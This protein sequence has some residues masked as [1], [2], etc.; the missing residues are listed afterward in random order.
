MAH[1]AFI[2]YSN[3]DRTVADAA[4]AVLES[5]GIRCWIAPRDITPGL[6]WSEAIVDAIERSKVMVL[7]LSAHANGS[8]QIKREVE[9]GVNHGLPIIP[10][11]IEDVP[12]S[13]ALEYFIS[14]PHW[15]DALTPPLEEHLQYLADTVQLLLQRRVGASGGTDKIRVQRESRHRWTE[16]K[17]KA[18][19]AAVGV[20]ALAVV[21]TGA[22]AW[23]RFGERFTN[24]GDAPAR[25]G[26]GDPSMD[27]LLARV[28]GSPG[29]APAQ[30]GGSGGGAVD[31]GLVGTWQTT[32]NVSGQLLQ[33]KMVIAT[34]GGYHIDNVIADSGRF[35]VTSAH[36]YRMM[37]R[38]GG[39]IDL[40]D[41]GIDASRIVLTGPLGT[42]TW[43]RVGFPTNSRYPIVGDW[44]STA[45]TNGVTWQVELKV[46]ERQWLYHLT[47]TSV[48]DGSM[49][50]QGGQWTTR[51][52]TLGGVTAN[53]TYIVADRSSMTL[54][55]PP[56]GVTSWT[57]LR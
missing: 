21:G 56:F 7:V 5:R 14:S 1:D 9:R 32:T 29:A 11:R 22:W 20:V 48:D 25:R 53:G 15:L 2:S 8:P 47:S 46:E 37:P 27:S 52:R 10:F 17:R 31:R 28:P 26:S 51:S 12:L 57:R 40:T 44:R 34:D 42:Q 16:L 55:G 39:N 6:D 24:G 38:G 19:L 36:G 23:G 43:T 35:F 4:V 18:R 30:Q 54:N 33:T 3:L 13:K 50:A 45:V 41:S 49:N